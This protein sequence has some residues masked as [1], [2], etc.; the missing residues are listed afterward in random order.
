MSS[1]VQS[2]ES[3]A[4]MA[5]ESRGIVDLKHVTRAMGTDNI[6]GIPVL[7]CR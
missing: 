3:F 5:E 2:G 7:C 1:S 4:K 6:D